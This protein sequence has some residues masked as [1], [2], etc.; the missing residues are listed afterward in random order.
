MVRN[1][2]PRTSKVTRSVGGSAW[3]S[4]IALGVDEVIAL[5]G[6]DFIRTGTA[7]PKVTKMLFR[8]FILC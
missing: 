1:S 3:T 7:I 5:M 4:G 8:L 6:A 2:R